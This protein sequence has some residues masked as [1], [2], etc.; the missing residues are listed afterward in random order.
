MAHI[1]SV[2]STNISKDVAVS[3]KLG[4]QAEINVQWQCCLDRHPH[5]FAPMA[6]E[7]DDGK[8]VGIRAFTIIDELSMKTEWC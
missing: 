6:Q 7:H 4:S 3:W 2:Y 5:A 8:R 1:N